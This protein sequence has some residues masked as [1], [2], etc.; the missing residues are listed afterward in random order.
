MINNWAEFL[1]TTM[2]M[3]DYFFQAFVN[4]SSV[5]KNVIKK[6]A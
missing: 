5:S 3:W 4:E 6:N 1:T 2:K